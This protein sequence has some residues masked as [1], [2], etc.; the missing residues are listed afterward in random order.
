MSRRIGTALEAAAQSPICTGADFRQPFKTPTAGDAQPGPGLQKP[1]RP[2][3]LSRDLRDIPM[4]RYRLPRDGRK[5]RAIA[6]ERMALAEWLA[7]H[8]D[9]DGSRIWPAVASII[10]HFGWSRGKTF[11]L[12]DDLKQLRLLESRG[13][14]GERGPRERAMNI[15]AF[16]RGEAL[17][18]TEVQHSE[19]KSN[20]TVDTTDLQTDK[21]KSGSDLRFSTNCPTPMTALSP[22]TIEAKRQTAR[23]IL[24]REGGYEPD[25]V[26]VALLRVEDLARALNKTPRSVAYFVASVKNSLADEDE[27]ELCRFIATE[28][29]RSDVPIDA[30][31]RPDEWHAASKIAFVHAVVEDASRL[32]RPAREIGAER[33]AA[34]ARGT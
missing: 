29:R 17:T 10:R 21:R 1:A 27:T 20:V 28:R 13:L 31:L 22:R 6:R 23:S 7:T 24:I 4:V 16:L 3:R 2:L 8:G 32:G 12:L 34:A 19:P 25:M 9:P 5:W 15:A 26:D 30:P 18:A 14:H 33:L 11:Y